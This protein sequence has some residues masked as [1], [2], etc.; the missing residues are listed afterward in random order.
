MR[1]GMAMIELIFAIVIIAISVLSIP[2]MMNVASEAS[3]SAVIDEDIMSRLSGW[4][5]EN[6][7][8]RWDQNYAASGSGPLW[9]SGS[10][11]LECTRGSENVWYRVNQN[12]NIQCDD[13]NRTPSA[14]GSAGAGTADGNLSK[15]I[16]QLN[17]GTETI[18]VIA[19]SGEEYNVSATYNVRYVSSSL[20]NVNGNTATA[21][22]TLGSSANMAP[23]GSTGT[24]THLKRVV[25]RFY[26]D[27]LDVDTTLTFFKSNK[28]N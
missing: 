9:I 13:Q 4:T 1:S 2:S 28:G 23:D 6:F 8:A 24:A 12:S 25:T 20:T 26:N 21:T 17:G 7:Q 22:W 16:E 19:A 27:E 14:I 3:K 18:T 10:G 15:G 11:D 5:L